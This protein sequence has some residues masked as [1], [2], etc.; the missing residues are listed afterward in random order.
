MKTR[1]ITRR[2]FLT[3]SSL[4]LAAPVIVPSSVLGKD[5]AVAPS[6]KIVLGAIGIGPRGKYVLG[7]MMDEPDVK[8]V[9]ICDVHVSKI[10]QTLR[11]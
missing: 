1:S 8:F 9:A 4:A 3:T 2:R 5:G 7:R 6:E 10:V 11:R